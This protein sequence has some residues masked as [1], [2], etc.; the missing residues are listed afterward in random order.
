[1]PVPSERLRRHATIR[2]IVKRHAVRNQ[3]DLAKRL[4]GEGIRVTQS[5]LSR[6]L[7]ELGIHRA[8]SGTYVDPSELPRTRGALPGDDRSRLQ[9]IAPLEITSIDANET[10]VVIRTLVG[11]AQ[12]LAVV[13]DHLGIEEILGTIAGDDTILVLPR[14]VRDVAR[15]KAM[16]EERFGLAR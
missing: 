6:D 2:E 11:R 14:S 16:L 12:G 8:A 7:R 9:S 5:T 3:T 1:M 13:L 4:L 10:A 15:L